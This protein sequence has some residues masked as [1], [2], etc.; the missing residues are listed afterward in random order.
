[1]AKGKARRR[2][3]RAGKAKVTVKITYA[4]T[5]G[6]ANTKAKTIKLIKRR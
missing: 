4:P 6:L 3:D 5:G 1:M 2:L